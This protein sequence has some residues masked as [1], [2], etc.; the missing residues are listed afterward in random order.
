MFEY[1]M[2]FIQNLKLFLD[3]E[4]F[5]FFLETD[6]FPFTINICKNMRIFWLL[7]FMWFKCLRGEDHYFLLAL[8][9]MFSITSG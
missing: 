1:F 6:N 7:Y 8:I 4:V 2:C 9:K 3:K 5:D